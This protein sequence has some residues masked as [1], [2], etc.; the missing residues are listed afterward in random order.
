MQFTGHHFTWLV[1]FVTA[2]AL[3]QGY[4]G[5]DWVML[6][7]QPI[8]VIGTAVAFYLGFKNNQAYDRLW[9]ARKVWGA[10]VNSSRAWGSS[11]KGFVSNQFR[12]ESVSDEKLHSIRK[13]LIYRHIAWLYTLRKQLLV[14]TSWEHI[15]QWGMVAVYARR[16]RDRVGIGT[17]EDQLEKT[18]LK[19]FVDQ[20]ELDRLNTFKNKA[21]Q[22]VDQQSEDL[23]ALRSENLIDDFRQ[24]ELQ[25][26][27]YDFYIHQG[28]LERIKKF[29][30]PR[31]YGSMSFVLVG[32]F[33]AVLPFG[34]LP[35]F[36][37]MGAIGTWIG[38]LFTVLVSWV[39]LVMELV[40]DYTENPFEGSGNDIPMLSLCRTIEIDLKE[41]LR[42]ED[43]PPGIQPVN[44][45]LM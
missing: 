38:V 17:V 25:R 44:N 20:D 31:Q 23:R 29:P 32:I 41:M 13:K 14:P 5:L 12:E 28:K 9:E 22:L 1:P 33:I 11:V 43:I 35:L 2:S 45:V 8:A 10:I 24:M 3:L 36:A 19:Y 26:V 6:P 7:W 15:N 30:L 39:F 37:D 42:E 18:D 16:R 34:L 21:T 4:S 27:L 40:G